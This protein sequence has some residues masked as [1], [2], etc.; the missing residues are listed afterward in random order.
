MVALTPFDYTLR[1]YTQDIVGDGYAPKYKYSETGPKGTTER[2]L[3][4]MYRQNDYYWYDTDKVKYQ[5]TLPIPGEGDQC[6]IVIDKLDKTCPFRMFQFGIYLQT[7]RKDLDRREDIVIKIYGGT[8]PEENEI[9][10]TTTIRLSGDRTDPLEKEI[11]QHLKT[12]TSA[13]VFVPF[14]ITRNNFHPETGEYVNGEK[15]WSIAFIY[16]RH[17]NVKKHLENSDMTLEPCIPRQALKLVVETIGARGL[18]G[19]DP[20]D[21]SDSFCQGTIAGVTF[22]TSTRA[23]TCDPDWKETSSVPILKEDWNKAT[24]KMACFESKTT[25]DGKKTSDPIPLG[26][27][28]IPSLALIPQAPGQNYA[29]TLLAG[30]SKG[31]RPVTGTVLL[32]FK[33]DRDESVNINQ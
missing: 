14:V 32:N 18:F 20:D 10:F 26:E 33:Y 8:K 2:D 25:K 28:E 13:N 23:Q 1:E 16:G 27:F 6:Q 15:D 21:K 5:T 31:K 3:I 22:T 24:L 19:G 17:S 7:E 29:F 11:F 30:E 12:A 4:T 9:L